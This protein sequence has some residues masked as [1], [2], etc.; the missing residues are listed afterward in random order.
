[1]I[2]KSLSAFICS[3][4]F[5]LFAGTA[6]SE[7][8][9]GRVMSVSSGDNFI[10]FA[11]DGLQVPVQLYGVA[12]PERSQRHGLEAANF[13]N[14]LI[15][16]RDVIVKVYSSDELGRVMGVVTLD[17]KNINRSMIRQGYAWRHAKECRKA[18][19]CGEW[20]RVQEEARKER[21]GVWS[22]KE[23]IP[24]WEWQQGRRQ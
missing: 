23:P 16:Q 12:A 7:E 20:N 8:I 1:M 22:V 6:K 11:T 14:Y 18:S 19:F 2:L 4:A 13:L 24:P 5:I 15:L 17:D 9:Q 3:L 10:M 21:R